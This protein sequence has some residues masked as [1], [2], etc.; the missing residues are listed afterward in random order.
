DA[1][2]AVFIALSPLVLGGTHPI[3]AVIL[4]AAFALL[5]TASMGL[6]AVYKVAP[7]RAW[8]IY[9]LG[10]LCAW[11]LL[12]STTLGAWTNPMIVRDAWSIWPEISARGGIAPGRAALWVI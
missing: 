10:A 7:R 9:A 5:C 2:F 8:P 4:C 6:H 3:A 11:T 1:V 12:R